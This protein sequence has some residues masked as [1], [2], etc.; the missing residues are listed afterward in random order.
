MADRDLIQFSVHVL[1]S[2]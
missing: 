1:K 2:I